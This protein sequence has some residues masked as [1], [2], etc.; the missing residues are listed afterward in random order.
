MDRALPPFSVQRYLAIWVLGMIP[1]VGVIVL[2]ARPWE[3]TPRQG[4][5]ATATAAVQSPTPSA[6]PT[7]TATAAVSILSSPRQSTATPV[8]DKYLVIETEKGRVVARLRTAAA[9]G[10]ARSVEGFAE[11]V[12]SGFFDGQ[13]FHRVEEWMVQGGDPHG[14]SRVTAEYNNIP[15]GPGSLA[16]PHGVDPAHNSD[17]QLIIF[18]STTSALDKEYTNLGQV[19]EG[20]DVVNKLVQG[21][22]MVKVTVA[23]RP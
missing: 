23:G 12:E 15:F 22:K 13:Q 16:L 14:T 7:A 11:K 4:G 17:T 3:A 19:I 18:K 10:V 2:L 5:A 6:Q 20:M 21:D 8:P 9:E 1:L